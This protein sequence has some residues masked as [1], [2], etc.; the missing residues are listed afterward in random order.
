MKNSL[1]PSFW[2]SFVIVVGLIGN[3]LISPL[4]P[5]YAS[6]WDLSTSQI[7]VL[8]VVYMLGALLGLLC[9]GSLPDRLGYRSILGVSLVLALIGTVITMVSTSLPLL[10][11]GRFIVGICSSFATTSGAKGLAVNTPD[12]RKGNLAL[13][14]NLL[15]ALGFGLGPLIG[16]IAGQ[17]APHPLVT[18]HIPTLIGAALALVAVIFLLPPVPASAKKPVQLADF[19]PSLVLPGPESRFVYL[20]GCGLPFIAFGVFS[21]YASMAPLF[22]AELLHLKGPLI[23]G[24]S[25]TVILLFS[26]VCQ[27]A[28]RRL[29]SRSNAIIGMAAVFL[30]NLS[31]LVNLSTQSAVLFVVGLMTSAL[32][33]GASMLSGM[34]LVNRMATPDNRSGLT[35]TFM[36][37][38]YAGAILPTLAMGWIADHGGLDLAVVTFCYVSGG[39]ALTVTLLNIFCTRRQG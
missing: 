30:S 20:L 2:V 17:W 13:V 22:V 8:Y 12:H 36:V 1:S 33:H 23:S 3:A 28:L 5:L 11:V 27:I 29:P 24:A 14:T 26:S 6:S 10:L 15:I 39:M 4:Y 7:S 25:I 16:G 31:L 9:F 21:L 37:V 32:G 19:L 34:T 35:A 38:G 18:A